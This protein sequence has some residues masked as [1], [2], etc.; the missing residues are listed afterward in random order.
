[1]GKNQQA[2]QRGVRMANLWKKFKASALNFDN[3]CVTWARLKK[4]PTWVG[5]LPTILAC[6]LLFTSI[7]MGS[8]LIAF[9][10]AFVFG[11]AFIIEQVRHNACIENEGY[12]GSGSPLSEYRDGDQGFGLYCGSYRIDEED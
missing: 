4:L 7:V 8:A 9:S 1:M 12:E 10:L 6:M 3:R 2:W 11:L 5:H